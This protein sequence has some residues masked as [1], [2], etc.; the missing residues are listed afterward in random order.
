M[1]MKRVVMVVTVF[2]VVLGLDVGVLRA[3]P[4]AKKAS[5]PMPTSAPPDRAY[6]E[7]TVGPTFGHKSSASFGAEGGYWFSDFIG[8][9][10][11]LGRMRDVATSDIEDKAKIIAGGINGTSTAKQPATYFD[12]G[13]SVRLLTSSR[14][15]PYALLGFGFARVSNDVRFAINGTDV[16]S[17]LP[18]LGV[19]IGSDLSGDYSKRFITLGFGTH[20][21]VAARWLADVSYRYGSIGATTELN[22]ISTNRLQFGIGAKF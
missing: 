22:G 20:I 15:T 17:Q 2:V 6:A 19:Q 18:Q 14:F 5:A 13:V 10:A 16:T 1:F 9:F 7:F 8:V 12:A 21:N 11:E 4:A 3:Q